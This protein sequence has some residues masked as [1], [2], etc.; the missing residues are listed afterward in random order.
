VRHATLREKI[1]DCGALA[2]CCLS[3]YRPSASGPYGSAIALAGT[4]AWFSIRGMVVLFPGACGGQEQ[5]DGCRIEQ[6]T[7][8][9]DK[10]AQDVLVGGAE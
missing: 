4:A 5:E 9:Q 3:R 2:R 7:D 8:H 6:E 1:R 10:R